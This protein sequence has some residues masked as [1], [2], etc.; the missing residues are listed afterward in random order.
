M[1]N[2]KNSSPFTEEELDVFCRMDELAHQFEKAYEEAKVKAK[3]I[4]S[5]KLQEKV[6]NDK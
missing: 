3:T 6:S 5:E 2:K 4:E 1:E